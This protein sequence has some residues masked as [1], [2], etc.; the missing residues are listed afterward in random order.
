MRKG[1]S[2]LIWLIAIGLL[3]FT[4]F[5]SLHLIQTT[6]PAD[7]QILGFAGLAGLDLGLLAW[8]FYANGGARGNQRTVALL[9]IVVNFAGV[10]AA[11]L[12]DTLLIV[13]AKENQALI[14]TVASWILPIIIIANVGAVIACHVMDPAQALKDAERQVD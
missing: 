13:G 14:S 4:G 8:T 6:L 11:T 7:A 12:A 3:V 10:A 9:M 2:L 1:N 5:R